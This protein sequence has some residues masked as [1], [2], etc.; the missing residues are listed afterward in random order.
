MFDF[1]N[2]SFSSLITIFSAIIGLA[3]PVLLQSIQRI[4]EQ[5]N[6]TRLAYRFQQENVFKFFKRVLFIN[7]IISILCPF[8]LYI[9]NINTTVLFVTLQTIFISAL[10]FTSFH[11]FEII[12]IYYNPKKLLER[13]KYSLEK[14]KTSMMNIL[15]KRE[16]NKLVEELLNLLDL[17]IYAARKTDQ[18]I[19]YGS[20]REIYFFVYEYQKIADKSMPVVYPNGFMKVFSRIRTYST[21]EKNQTY[22]YKQN[23][24]TSILLGRLYKHRISD[25]TYMFLW[26]TIN[27]V[28]ASNNEG[29]FNQ[30]WSIVDQYYSL[31][32][33]N[34]LLGDSYNKEDEQNKNDQQD[35]KRFCEQHVM[36]GAL[37]VY[38]D[39]YKWLNNIM[40]YT[41]EMP[42]HYHLIP[43]TFAKIFD[44]L[45]HFY[46]FSSRPVFKILS[47][48]YPFT[49]MDAD[50]NTDYY[51][52]KEVKRY[53][54]LLVIRLFLVNNNIINYAA[55]MELPELK[56]NIVDNEFKI[57][58]VQYLIEGVNQWYKEKDKIYFHDIP[59]QD[60]VINLLNSYINTLD[61]ANKSIKNN[62]E[63]DSDKI[64][65]L[66][67]N[68]FEHEQ[69][70]RKDI[71]TLQHIKDQLKLV[72]NEN[73][74]AKALPAQYQNKLRNEEILKGYSS[75]SVNLEE[76]LIQMI[77]DSIHRYYINY[78]INQ[79]SF[80]DYTIA[81]EDIF[82]SFDKLNLDSKKH[83][84]LSQ[85]VSL[86]NFEQQYGKQDKFIYSPDAEK[87]SYND[88]VIKDV[89]S[90]EISF[91]ILN[92]SDLP[93]YEFCKK[94]DDDLNLIDKDSLLYS[95]LDNINPK[96]FIL[97][98]KYNLKF[99][100]NSNLF[101]IRL[102]VSYNLPLG[103]NGD[104]DSIKTIDESMDEFRTSSH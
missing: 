62:P 94:E 83:I 95:N 33:Q 45:E 97:K 51:I 13:L 30:Y 53:L 58:L 44:Q 82:K 87:I 76:D 84:I 59:K 99:Y 38:N 40:F 35:A 89:P 88:V 46:R 19:Y 47:S 26:L 52:F 3:Y 100:S 92:I 63:I 57:K 48:K 28:I 36:L 104:L 103:S 102:K 22:F 54:S 43:G 20:I 17:S 60:D 21:D 70:S 41:N 91:L 72:P 6:S 50:V 37:L 7:I 69:K 71:I 67:K 65:K 1:T 34:L 75:Y 81:Y 98:L 101:F 9:S 90:T 56:Y 79:K 93:Y 27:D 31:S 74:E 68:L 32:F 29:W 16:D 61:N 42:P 2:S 5:Y 55:P 11:L 66:K 15:K 86:D 39:K 8:I 4:D 18:D 78:F 73:L 49:G 14:K 85:G 10:L 77:F 24:I 96:D 25:Q 12:R 64:D 23:E 80:K